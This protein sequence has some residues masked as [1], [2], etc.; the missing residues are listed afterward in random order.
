M[1]EEEQEAQESITEQE[2]DLRELVNWPEV[3]KPHD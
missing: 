3:A 1:T 2:R